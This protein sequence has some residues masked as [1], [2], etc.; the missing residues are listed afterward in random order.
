MDRSSTIPNSGQLFKTGQIRLDELYSRCKD[1]CHIIYFISFA[2]FD[3]VK[4]MDLTHSCGNDTCVK[5]VLHIL[6]FALFS[7]RLIIQAVAKHVRG[8]FPTSSS[9][10]VGP[11]AIVTRGLR[12]VRRHI[13][14]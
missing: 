12:Y 3:L 5:G 6:T 9:S 10:C 4:R 2:A 7:F 8:S 1:L 13:S 11:E 14:E